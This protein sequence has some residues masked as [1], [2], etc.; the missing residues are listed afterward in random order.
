MEMTNKSATSNVE[1]TRE[2]FEEPITTYGQVVRIEQVWRDSNLIP[3]KAPSTDDVSY[4]EQ[5]GY[6]VAHVKRFNDGA[7]IRN[8]IDYYVELPLNKVSGTT[9]CFINEKLKDIITED[10]TNQSYVPTIFINGKA[11]AYGVGA[12]LF[13]QAAGTLYFQ[14]ENFVNAIKNKDVTITFYKYVG[15]KGTSVGNT[16]DNA[17]LPFRDT[18]KHFKNAEND[19]NTATFKVRGDN[20]NTNYVLPPENGKWY[21]KGDATDTGVVLLQ[22]NLEDVLWVQNTKISGGEWIDI[23][24]SKKVFRHKAPISEKAEDASDNLIVD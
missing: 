23:E 22:E 20:K 15:R 19:N 1:S 13:D 12:P 14:D 6:K 24:G 8:L 9:N 17:D 4:M 2:K 10:T 21:D 5:D 18:I 3:D 16:L 7:T 11:I